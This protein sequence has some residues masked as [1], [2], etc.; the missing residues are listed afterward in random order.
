MRFRPARRIAALLFAGA[1]ALLPPAS[2]RA[3]APDSAL[4]RAAIDAGNTAFIRAWE[5]GDADLFASLFADDGALLRPGGGLTVGR[6]EIRGRMRQVFARVRMTAGT[7]TTADVFVIGETAYETGAWNFTIGPIGSTTIEPDSGHYVE[8]WKRDGS[9]AWKIWRDIGVPKGVAAAGAPAPAAIQSVAPAGARLKAIR[10]GRLLD[11]KGHIIPDALVVVDGDRVL[12]VGPYASARVPAGAEPLDLTRLTGIP[13]LIDAHTHMTYWWDRAPGTRPWQE[14]D[15][16]PPMQTM[17]LA[18][19]NA[20]KTLEAGVTTVRDLGSFQYMDIAMRDLI[21]RGAMTGPRMLVAGYGLYPTMSPFQDAPQAA[22]GGLA[23]GVDQV[24]RATRQQIAAGADVIKIY[25]STG[26]ADDVTGYQTYT[27]E[28]MKAAIDLA[29]LR[30]K[31]VSVHSYG[32]DGA[33]DAV[34]AGATSVEHAIDIDDATLREMARRG[35]YYVPT[36]D[37]NRYYAEHGAEFG[38]GDSAVAHLNAYRAKNFETL[39][40]AIRARVPIAMG[41]DAVFTMFG[42]NTRELAWFVKAG[43]TPAQALATATGNGAALLGMEKELGAIAPGY[44]ADLVG[45]EGDPETDIGA[46]IGRVRWVMKGGRV[47]VDHTAA[48]MP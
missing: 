34:R 5:L 20:R 3:S 18:Q 44:Y 43:M 30:G 26:S 27:Y 35:V 10:F 40:R 22:A 4:V 12:S 45:V 15:A 7:I 48:A 41:S 33:R 2:A 14:L 32:P 47:V 42:E 9:D 11:G 19:E 24:L 6:E 38:Y 1:L 8:V 13:G 25:G 16:R 23:D 21:N 46:V 37:H 17:F 39:R 31:R 29:R 28:E 36:V